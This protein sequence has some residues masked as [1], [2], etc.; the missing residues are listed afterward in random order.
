MSPEIQV[1]PSEALRAAAHQAV[2][3]R[4]A[5]SFCHSTKPSA[6]FP[7]S[8]LADLLAFSCSR[9]VD[10]ATG[11]TCSSLC[12]ACGSA[13]GVLRS[14]VWSHAW[15]SFLSSPS[16]RSKGLSLGGSFCHQLWGLFLM[17]LALAEALLVGRMS[18]SSPLS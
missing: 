6:P 10:N 2:R 18:V 16:Q 1:F 5:H 7:S 8:L 13:G 11:A 9:T 3:L 12:L 17:L 4:N 15:N 14:L